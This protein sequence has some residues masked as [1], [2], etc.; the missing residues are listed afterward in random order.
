MQKKILEYLE[1]HVGPFDSEEAVIAWWQG[2][3][4][5]AASIDELTE[6]L[7]YL[8]DQG[9][10]EKQKFGEDLFTYGIIAKS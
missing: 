7:E 10:I 1:G 8:E 2:L 9:V 6:T 3:Q 5:M 4:D